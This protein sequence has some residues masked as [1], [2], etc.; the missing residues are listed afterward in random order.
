MEAGTAVVPL[1][2]AV[3][4]DPETAE[5]VQTYA[6]QL[7]AKVGK[8]AA[9]SASIPSPQT[10]ALVEPL[11]PR[12]LEV[13]ALV[14]VGDANQEIADKLFITVRTVKKHVTSILSKLGV[15]NRTQAAARA[16]ELGLDSSD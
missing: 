8:G 6:G 2:Q 1:L 10:E 5:S 7:L 16:H 13:L 11:T 3:V 15:S 12:E 4:Q 9:A 14:A